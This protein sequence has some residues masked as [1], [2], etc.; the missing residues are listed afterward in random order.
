MSNTVT[1]TGYIN[2]KDTRTGAVLSVNSK[3]LVAYSRVTG[4]RGKNSEKPIMEWL[5]QCAY[6]YN[7]SNAITIAAPTL[8]KLIAKLESDKARIMP[9]GK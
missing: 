3:N 8:P 6:D 7:I 1:H 5:V 9:Y 4:W 2:S